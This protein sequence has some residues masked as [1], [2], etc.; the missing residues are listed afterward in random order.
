VKERTVMMKTDMQLKQDVEDELAWDPKVNA[1][2]IG[3]SVQKGAVSLTGEV[4]TYAEKWAAEDAAKRVSGVRSVAEDLTVKILGYHKHS[5]AEIAQ[6]AASALKWH[7]WIPETVKAT[8]H[9]GEVDL[10]GAVEWKYQSNSAEEAVRHLA[11]VTGVNNLITIRPH[12]DAAQVKEK[13]QAALQRQAVEDVKSIHVSASG[14]TVTLSGDAS[15]W[16]TADDAVAAAWAA[17]GVNDVV[18]K[19]R[20]VPA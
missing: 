6:A 5:D 16:K 20:V 14:A 15:S 18:D 11:G 10:E 9:D 19:L 17:P 1:A 3:V 4:D 13:V 7:V 2:R 8:V 12:A